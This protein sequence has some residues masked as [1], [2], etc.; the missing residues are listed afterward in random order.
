[1]N[2]EIRQSLEQENWLYLKIIRLSLLHPMS[3]VMWSVTF[4]HSYLALRFFADVGNNNNTNSI[5]FCRCRLRS[6]QSCLVAR[7]GQRTRSKSR[8]RMYSI[9]SYG[10]GFIRSD[11]M[12]TVVTGEEFIDFAEHASLRL[13]SLA[14]TANISLAVQHWIML[15]GV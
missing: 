12:K 1:M 4:N 6:T 9:A 10:V 11:M 5:I 15:N 8:Y 7:H 13:S 3:C 14:V 2:K